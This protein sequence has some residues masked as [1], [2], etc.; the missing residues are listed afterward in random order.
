MAEDR[1]LFK[2]AMRK[3][4]LDA[5]ER[6]CE[7]SER[8]PWNL[9]GASAFPSSYVRRLRWAGAGG[10]MAYNREE[11]LEILARGLDLSPVHEVLVEES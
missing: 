6:F 10:G 2:D 7:R 4:G 8:R 3:I 5:Q 11:F 1:L 9:P